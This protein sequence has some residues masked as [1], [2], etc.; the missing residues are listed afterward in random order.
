MIRPALRLLA[1]A[2]FLAA[3]VMPEGG[4]MGGTGGGEAAGMVPV[5][6]C[7]PLTYTPATCERIKNGTA[8]EGAGWLTSSAG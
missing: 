6:M 7:D 1:L 2:P 4:G 5:R 3:C 8:P